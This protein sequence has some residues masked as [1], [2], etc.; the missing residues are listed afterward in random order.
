MALKKCL[1]AAVLVLVSGCPHL[2]AQATPGSTSRKVQA[3]PPLP[4]ASRLAA[5]SSAF[6]GFS[7]G[8]NSSGV[9]NS[10]I[11]WYSV[12]SPA[13]GYTFSGRYSADVSSAVYFDHQEWHTLSLSSSGSGLVTEGENVGDTLFAFHTSFQ[14]GSY[15]DVITATL[16][17]PTGNV[18]A[19][20]GTGRVTYDLTN[21]VERYHGPLGLFVD[22]GMGD[23]SVLFNNT[24]ARNYSS[25]GALAHFLTGADCWIGKRAFIE[26]LA[27]EQLPLG[28][29]KLYSN[30]SSASPQTAISASED[31]GFTTY[32]GIP[33]GRYITFGGYYD[34]SLR[35]H[36]D[37]VSLGFTFFLQGKET[38]EDS[39]VDRALKEAEKSNP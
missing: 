21:H 37:T 39:L 17:A 3:A 1:L 23:S 10:Y 32:A 5:V 22:L 16:S 25:L 29:Q 9:H 38:V 2:H 33:F 4:T 36:T 19:G 6:R 30:S 26:P 11:G 15:Q 8:L 13:L 27:Y 18:N 12:L 31:N 34:R 14:P 7:L 28:S 20:L 24:V 35:N